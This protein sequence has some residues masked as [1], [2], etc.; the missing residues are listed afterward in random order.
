MF[1]YVLSSASLREPENCAMT[2]APPCTL[3]EIL[4]A[5]IRLNCYLV[6]GDVT[7]RNVVPGAWQQRI[8][9]TSSGPVV[10]EPPPV[11]NKAPVISYD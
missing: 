8:K 6:L 5:N 2:D 1:G 7:F 4:S 10:E 11:T 9:I 3:C